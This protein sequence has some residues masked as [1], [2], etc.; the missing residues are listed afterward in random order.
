MSISN[1]AGDLIYNKT[2]YA[3]D[4]VNASWF[5]ELSPMKGLT[6][7]ARFGM[8]VDNTRYNDLGNTYM[9]QSASY[10]GTASQAH[11]RKFGFDQQFVG[12]YQF[13]FNDITISILRQVTM[14]ITMST[15]NCPVTQ[16][17][18]TIR[19]A[20]T[21]VTQS[22]TAQ[23]MVIATRMP[24]AVISDVSIIRMMRNI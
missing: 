10:G 17:I 19:K 11:F 4:I 7:T 14:D 6:L 9:G 5:A 3:A 21:L 13:S 18:C 23:T 16:Q 8:N 20:S 15:R 12:N 2:Q 24:H 1:P 22:I